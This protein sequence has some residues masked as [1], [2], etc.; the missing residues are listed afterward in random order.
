MDSPNLIHS[1][2]PDLSEQQRRQ[3]HSL[4]ELYSHW[5]TKINLISRK[6]I[7]HLYEHHILHSLAIGKIL[8][9][10]R[11]TRILDIGTG[12]GFPGIPLAILFPEVQFHLVDSIEKKIKAVEAIRGE[13]PLKNVTTEAARAEKIAGKYEFIICRALAPLAQ[14]QVWSAD[15]ISERNINAVSNGI[16]ALKGGDLDAELSRFPKK[17]VTIYWLK[18]YFPNEFF[19]TKALIHLSATKY[20]NQKPSSHALGKRAF[21]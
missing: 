3:F 8:T 21:R 10:N 16:L 20:K 17:S 2:F 18:K 7:I 9:F 1:F 13:L 19:E 5:N 11:G 12:G 15:K 6:D 14:I 4:G